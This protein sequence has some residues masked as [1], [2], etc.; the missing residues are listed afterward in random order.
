MIDMEK[1]GKRIA[2]LRKEQGYTGEALDCS[3]DSLLCPRELFILGAVYTDGQ[4]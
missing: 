3:I 1:T 4:P 2:V